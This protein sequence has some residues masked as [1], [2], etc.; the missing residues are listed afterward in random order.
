MIRKRLKRGNQAHQIF[1]SLNKTASKNS[2][3]KSQSEN[4]SRSL[5][6]RNKSKTIQ[7]SEPPCLTQVQYLIPIYFNSKIAVHSIPKGYRLR[8][9][10]EF[11]K[12]VS[13]KLL[14]KFTEFLSELILIIIKS[15]PQAPEHYIFA[16][17]AVIFIFCNPV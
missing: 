5:L 12:N 11:N 17:N 16:S 7:F 10:L 2:F 8:L 13:N 6:V 14:I 1:Q 15:V 3:H 4:L 9:E